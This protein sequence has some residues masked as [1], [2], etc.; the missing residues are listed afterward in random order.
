HFPHSLGIF[1]EALTQYLGF[2]HYGDEYKVMGLAAYGKPGFMRE[3]RQILCL[4]EGASFRLNLVF[5]RHHS[6]KVNYTWRNCAPSVDCLST[7]ALEDLWGPARAESQRIKQHHRDIARSVQAMYE[8]AFFYLLNNVH[9]RC[10]AD[11]LALAGGCAMN[12]VANGKIYKN[13]PFKRVF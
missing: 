5:F 8:E 6:E 11:T 13:T 7:R 12:S 2:P 9:R 3:M 1:Y 10:N 4:D